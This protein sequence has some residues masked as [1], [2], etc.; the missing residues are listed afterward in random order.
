MA[1]FERIQSTC[2]GLM[3]SL[4]K[5]VA[6]EFYFCMGS[7][8]SSVGSSGG[9]AVHSIQILTHIFKSLDMYED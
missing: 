6:I 2:S 1:K 8:Q 7:Y 3:E 4:C 9:W 5:A